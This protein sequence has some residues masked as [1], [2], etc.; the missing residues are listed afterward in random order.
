M[1]IYILEI[2]N[3]AILL[4]VVWISLFCISYLYK[5]TL[6]FLFVESEIFLTNEFKVSYFI[7]TDVLEVFSVY[8]QLTFFVSYQIVMFYLIYHTFTF[9]KYALFKTEYY[10]LRFIINVVI[11]IWSL[12]AI[13][14]KYILI[15]SMWFF[16]VNFQNSNSLSLH[17]EAKLSEYLNF[18][19]KFYYVFVFYC[20]TFTFLFF[21][22][23]Y[24]TANSLLIRK[25]RKLYYYFMVLFA[26]LIS[27]PEILSQI[28]ISSIL[29]F[30]HE[31]FIIVFLFK[32]FV[33]L[34][35]K[36]AS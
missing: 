33:N 24:L 35:N 18:Y 2:K 1:F 28:F 9:F 22:F 23:N 20:Q 29:I 27:P 14:S 5:E 25:F 31:L 4:F 26:T 10:Y 13:I 15:P 7:F 32:Y 11:F 21:V 16:L 34:F 8:V 12:S 3:R 6:L 19:I 36:E 30:C 17:F